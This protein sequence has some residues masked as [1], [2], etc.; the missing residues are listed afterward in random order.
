[1]IDQETKNT[2]R[3][4]LLADEASWVGKLDDLVDTFGSDPVQAVRVKQFL[5]ERIASGRTTYAERLEE[6]FDRI[7]AAIR[8]LD[9][10]NALVDRLAERVQMLS[11]KRQEIDGEL[12]EAKQLLIALVGEQSIARG[13]RYRVK[14][15]GAGW[16]LR[17][18][19]KQ[20]IPAQWLSPQPDRRAILQHFKA[21]GEIVPGA[22]VAARQPAVHLSEIEIETETDDF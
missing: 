11:E 22:S 9:P 20:E 4:I 14:T 10:R 2:L 16:S 12:A 13:E 19:D 15:T 8:R 17:V 6:M 1:M 7:S 5:K 21:T 18:L 3:G